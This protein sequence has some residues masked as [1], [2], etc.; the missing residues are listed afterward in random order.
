MKKVVIVNAELVVETE[1][2]VIPVLMKLEP[3]LLAVCVLFLDILMT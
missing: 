1:T 2:I 3:T